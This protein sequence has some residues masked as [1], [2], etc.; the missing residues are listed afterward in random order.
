MGQIARCDFETRPCRVLISR[1]FTTAMRQSPAQVPAAGICECR[2]ADTGPGCRIYATRMRVRS[3]AGALS[4]RSCV[5][6]RKRSIRTRQSPMGCQI[7]GLAHCSDA[8]RR[9]VYDTARS[10][11]ETPSSGRGWHG[12][13]WHIPDFAPGGRARPGAI[14]MGS[15]CTLA[16]ESSDGPPQLSTET[17]GD[18]QTY[19]DLER[20]VTAE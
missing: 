6:R 13:C 7:A 14:P 9:I 4:V 12:C 16:A 5:L 11:D 1:I 8:T 17:V 20:G 18:K 3:A 19:N 10:R 15:R 2:I